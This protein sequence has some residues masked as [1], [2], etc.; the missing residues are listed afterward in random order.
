MQQERQVGRGTAQCLLEGMGTVGEERKGE[1]IHLP[2][3]VYSRQDSWNRRCRR[4]A[5]EDGQSSL[6]QAHRELHARRQHKG[7]AQGS[8]AEDFR[9]AQRA[10]VLPSKR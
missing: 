9:T 6:S 3:T 1:M 10:E 5:S 8:P 4:C 2:N 7:I